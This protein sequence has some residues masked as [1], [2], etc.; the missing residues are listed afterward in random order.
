MRAAAKDFDVWHLLW[1][2]RYRIFA[3]TKCTQ[4][5][6]GANTPLNNKRVQLKGRLN[7]LK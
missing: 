2:C 7:I 3:T 1:L 5:V 6:N 4:D